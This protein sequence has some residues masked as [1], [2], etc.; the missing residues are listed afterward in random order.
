MA[1]ADLQGVTETLR[2][3]TGLTM[4]LSAKIRSGVEKPKQAVGRWVVQNV[5]IA[6]LRGGAGVW[7][8]LTVHGGVGAVE[9]PVRPCGLAQHA[10]PAAAPADAV[11]TC[12]TGGLGHTDSSVPR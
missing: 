2:T 3:D 9:R 8:L 10:L 6:G 5:W 1:H 12:A 4:V 7:S 11:H